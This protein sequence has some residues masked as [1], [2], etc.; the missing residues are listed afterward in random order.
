MKKLSILLFAIIIIS[1]CNSTK[2]AKKSKHKKPDVTIITPDKEKKDSTKIE[3]SQTNIAIKDSTIRNVLNAIYANEL[4]FNTLYS[5][6]KTKA[7][8][9][10]KTQS[11][12]TQLR[13]H[14]NKKMWMSMTIIGIEGARVLINK[15]SIKIIDRLNSRNILKPI[16]YIQSKAY[17][18]LTF[19]D[20]EKLFLAQPIL[21]NTNKL[22]LVQNLTENILKS[23]DDRFVTIIKTDKQNR[24]K[25]IFVTD[26]LK[27][28][29]LNSDYSDYI[30]LNW[31]YFPKNRKI[32]IENGGKVFE[33][34]LEFGDI[35]LSK[36][37]SFPF[38]INPKYKNE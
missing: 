9:E 2:K 29:T 27:N 7:T 8:I 20:I 18:N 33:M 21:L 10:D 34:S 17:I 26:K 37:L 38:E 13:W 12:T 16:S 36:E 30:L 19:N 1:A 28:Q 24:L 22:E 23:N 32:R 6:I 35:D 5:K 3:I 31:K 15:D 14:K 4:K 25:N 11:F